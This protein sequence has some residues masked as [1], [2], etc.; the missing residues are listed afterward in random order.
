M[1]AAYFEH[2][3][4]LPPRWAAHAL[5]MAAKTKNAANW[6]LLLGSFAA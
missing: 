5:R 1:R 6:A 3:V 4:E 2:K